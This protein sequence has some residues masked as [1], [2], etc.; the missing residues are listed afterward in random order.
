MLNKTRQVDTE[1][2]VSGSIDE[3]QSTFWVLD[4]NHATNFLQ[5]CAE[6]QQGSD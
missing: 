6:I 4:T 2:T 3:L 5:K 1:K